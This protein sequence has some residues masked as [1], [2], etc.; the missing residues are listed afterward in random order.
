ASNDRGAFVNAMRFEIDGLL[1]QLGNS[2]GHGIYRDGSGTVGRGDGAYSVAGNVITLL[3]KADTKFFNK[4]MQL[5]FVINSAGVPTTAR[6]VATQRAQ[7][8]A[9]DEDA[10]TVTCALDV[11]GAALTA[12][13]TNY[14]SVTNTDWIVP[15]GDYTSTWATTTGERIKGLAAWLPLTAPTGG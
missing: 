3:N 4:G 10:G 8:T 1:R 5:D 6:A 9:I 15:I 7:V 2:L 12:F 14:T 11:T 13:S